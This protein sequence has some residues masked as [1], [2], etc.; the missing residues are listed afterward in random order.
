M[1]RNDGDNNGLSFPEVHKMIQDNMR[2]LEKKIDI[3][4]DSGCNTKVGCLAGKSHFQEHEDKWSSD[5]INL[6]EARKTQEKEGKEVSRKLSEVL[7]MFHDTIGQL[8]TVLKGVNELKINVK[9]VE[10]KQIPK[11]EERSE[12]RIKGIDNRLWAV[13]TIFVVIMG[14]LIWNTLEVKNSVKQVNLGDLQNQARTEAWLSVM[15]TKLTN[16]SEAQIEIEFNTRLKERKKLG[17]EQVQ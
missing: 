16:K 4:V 8:N 17:G 7:I 5:I 15:A 1:Q 11:S 12:K 2:T 3:M 9:D 6:K 14:G 13:I 10:K